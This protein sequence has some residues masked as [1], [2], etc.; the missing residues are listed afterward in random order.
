MRLRLLMMM[1]SL[2]SRTNL[3]R[4]SLPRGGVN[5]W[6][7]FRSF[8]T[9]TSSFHK[10]T[11]Q[12][13]SQ[14]SYLL[15][16]T[17]L[18]STTQRGRACYY[19]NLTKSCLLRTT[20]CLRCKCGHFS[21]TKRLATSTTRARGAAGTTRKA[22]RSTEEER[23]GRRLAEEKESR[24]ADKQA[25]RAAKAAEQAAAQAAKKAARQAAQ[26]AKKAEREA[27][28][29]AKKAARED[30]R[31][32]A[33]PARARRRTLEP[34]MLENMNKDELEALQ[35]ALLLDQAKHTQTATAMEANE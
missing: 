33:Q 32:S 10:T 35:A 1:M 11:T 26:A 18:A 5:Y 2:V 9:R 17:D 25:K 6:K 21:R 23:E 20:T 16:S 28:Q 29:A 22:G 7:F 12:C 14:C 24:K 3:H 27:A 13:P 8:W 19:K 31:A 15:Y 30:A 34:S 4:A